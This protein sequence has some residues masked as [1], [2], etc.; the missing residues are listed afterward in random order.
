M[1]LRIFKN[2][3]LYLIHGIIL[4]TNKIDDFPQ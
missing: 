4:F 3:A 1:Y 2:L